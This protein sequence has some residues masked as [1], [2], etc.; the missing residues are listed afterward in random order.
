MPCPAESTDSV[1]VPIQ[2]PGPVQAQA[3]A[4]A[5]AVRIDKWLWSVR[6]YKTR[7]NAAEACRCG[8][9]RIDGHPVK[10][11]RDVRP[12]DIIQAKTGLIQRTVRVLTALESR[13][14]AAKVPLHMED[15]TPPEELQRLKEASLHP[16]WRPPG[17]GRP[18]KKERRLLDE[19]LAP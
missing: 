18:T 1:K 19:F 12:G 13:V 10:A 6:L 14:G 16:A 4:Q 5:Q 7:S 17:S 15:L 11:S 9:V 8:H 2:I 3:Q